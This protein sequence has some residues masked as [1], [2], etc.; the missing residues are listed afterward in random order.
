MK[1]KLS[2]KSLKLEII[3]S[4]YSINEIAERTG[5]ARQT[6]SKALNNE[7]SVRPSTA[8]KIAKAFRGRC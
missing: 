1:V 6:I 3:R 2:L 7:I 4:G 5:L 8:G